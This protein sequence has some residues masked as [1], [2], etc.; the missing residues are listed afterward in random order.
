MLY[1]R[2]LSL[3]VDD[4]TIC[5]IFVFQMSNRLPPRKRDRTNVP[6]VANGSIDEVVARSRL[7]FERIGTSDSHGEY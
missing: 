3:P 7:R 4:R 1:T 2:T 5:F 6:A